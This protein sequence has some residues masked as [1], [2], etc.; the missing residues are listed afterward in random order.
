MDC[1]KLYA[2]ANHS[3][4]SSVKFCGIEKVTMPPRGGDVLKKLAQREMYWLYTLNTMTPNG[5]NDDSLKCFLSK[6]VYK[7]YPF[8]AI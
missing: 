7:L 8:I 5:L 4:A 3:S 2:E 6:R 1:A